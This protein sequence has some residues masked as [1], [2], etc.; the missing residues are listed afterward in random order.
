MSDPVWRI[1]E[2]R[3]DWTPKQRENWEEH[4]SAVA[5]QLPD[6]ARKW[7]LR[8]YRPKKRGDGMMDRDHVQIGEPEHLFKK[9]VEGMKNPMS[10]IQGEVMASF[11]IG[12]ET[13]E[14]VE[15][16]AKEY[17]K[18]T[19]TE[20]EKQRMVSEGRRLARVLGLD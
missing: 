10:S 11:G 12:S 3:D 15:E 1:D 20:R 4:G 9:K 18:A 7:Y 8:T 19:L 16:A 5:E 6:K 2:R 13:K 17:V 14:E